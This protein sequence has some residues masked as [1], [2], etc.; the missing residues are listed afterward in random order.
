MA[1]IYSF[2]ILLHPCFFTIN[3]LTN[4]ISKRKRSTGRAQDRC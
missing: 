1:N 4:E 2:L 3:N